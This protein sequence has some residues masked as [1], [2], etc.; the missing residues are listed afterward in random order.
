MCSV[1]CYS[2]PLGSRLDI[3]N[4]FC[5]IR[6]H[7]VPNSPLPFASF[8]LSHTRMGPVMDLACEGVRE[9]T[10]CNLVLFLSFSLLAQV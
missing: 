3:K 9:D 6:K 5:R 2:N 10:R 7:T 1:C 8:L 4:G